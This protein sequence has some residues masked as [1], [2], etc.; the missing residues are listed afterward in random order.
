MTIPTIETMNSKSIPVL[1]P[2]VVVVAVV[3]VGW[4][5]TKVPATTRCLKESNKKTEKYV[6]S[7][8]DVLIHNKIHLE[9]CQRARAV[10]CSIEN[11]PPI[12]SSHLQ[13]SRKCVVIVVAAKR[14]VDQHEKRLQRRL[15][16]NVER[17]RAVPVS[18]SHL[19]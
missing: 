4:W 16:T 14:C 9:R 8:I 3:V 5:K 2:I 17:P 10:A 13:H 12:G 11:R 15:G 18:N 19:K 6:E 7:D 1:V